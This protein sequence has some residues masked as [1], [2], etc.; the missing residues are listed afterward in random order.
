[1]LLFDSFAVRGEAVQYAIELAKRTNTG[2]V[3][4]A[5]LSADEDD[6]SDA[7]GELPAKLSRFEESLIGHMES[8][9]AAG[10]SAEAVVKTGDPSSELV[11]YLA[12]SGSL[13]TIV[14]GGQQELVREGVRGKKPHWLTKMKDVVECPVVI[15]SKKS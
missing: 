9:Q 14:W 7:G 6:L 8:A 11:K 1:M 12:A 4:L 3:V 2:L 15:P 5:L 13:Q 10:I